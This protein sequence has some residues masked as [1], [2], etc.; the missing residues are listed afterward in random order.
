[1]VIHITLDYRF[2]YIFW[3]ESNMAPVAIWLSHVLYFIQ[4]RTLS[5]A[6]SNL[7]KIQPAPHNKI[8]KEFIE[9]V[10]GHFLIRR[11]ARDFF[12]S[13]GGQLRALCNNL[14][15]H[16]GAQYVCDLFRYRWCTIF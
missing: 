10:F 2:L 9:W 11:W 12:K 5:F 14:I 16:T 4:K 1:M 13:A 8:I 7:K 3:F 15:V 6:L